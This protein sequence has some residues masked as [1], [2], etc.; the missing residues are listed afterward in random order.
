[1]R[2][3]TSHECLLRLAE[4]GF[5][6]QQPKRVSRCDSLS[7]SKGEIKCLIVRE[8]EKTYFGYW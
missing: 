6:A 2:L 1:M 4:G 7:V 5:I 3:R 8:Q